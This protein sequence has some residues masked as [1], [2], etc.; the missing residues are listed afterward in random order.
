MLANE[1]A[2]VFS[3]DIT[4]I[5]VYHR[6]NT[7]R[8]FC[9]NPAQDHITPNDCFGTSDVIISAVPSDKYKVPTSSIKHG[10]ICVN[11]ATGNNFE[12]EVNEAA[13]MFVRRVGG[14]TTLMLQM[15]AMTLFRRHNEVA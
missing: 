1:G 2:M 12:D 14:V 4:G 13:G 5:Q 9:I 10:A 11:V 3:I 8:R 15:N 6:H 7:S